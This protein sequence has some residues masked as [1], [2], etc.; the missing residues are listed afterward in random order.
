M[1]WMQ[2]DR[3]DLISVACDLCGSNQEDLLFIK[4]GFRYVRCRYCKMVYVNPRLKEHHRY[5]KI[6]GTGSMGHFH[7]S[8]K[9]RKKIR[10]E[11]QSLNIYRKKNLMLDIGAGRGW[12]LKEAAMAGWETWALEINTQA[13]DHLASIDLNQI[14]TEPAENFKAPANS[15]DV[16]RIWDVIEHLE[17]PRK[18]A[19]NI[20][21]VLRP[22]GLLLLSTTNFHSLSRI[23]NGPQWIYLNGADHI[24]L[25]TPE[26]I[27]NFLESVGFCEIRIST[28]G[29]KPERRLFFP[30]RKLPPPLPILYPFRNLIHKLV[31]FTKYGHAMTVKAIKPYSKAIEP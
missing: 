8:L 7:L 13:I 14:I 22:G 17:S 31:Q 25:F 28:K 26:T 9:D 10:K 29:F 6:T 23:I 15:F 3:K 20:F 21:T 30:Q 2:V 11:I 19:T 4:E 27:Q 18:A 16:V 1:V 5:Q 24:N 12:F